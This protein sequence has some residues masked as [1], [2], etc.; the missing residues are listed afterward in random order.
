MVARLLFVSSSLSLQSIAFGVKENLD[1][2]KH[3]ASGS[4]LR[5]IDRFWP[6]EGNMH[7]CALIGFLKG[8]AP[9]MRQM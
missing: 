8:Q 7:T 3:K 6:Y 1:E 9:R 4:I 2:F 5:S